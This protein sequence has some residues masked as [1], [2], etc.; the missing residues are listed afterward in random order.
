MAFVDLGEECRR[1]GLND[2]AVRV[3]RAGLAHHPD[4]LTA[5][6]TLGRALIE[7]D[8]LD[9]AFAQLTFVLDAAP[10]N[11]PATSALAEIYQRRGMMSEALVHYRRAL[12]LTQQVAERPHT[13]GQPE[14]TVAPQAPST[15]AS[16]TPPPVEDLFDFD[17]LLA[18]L[19]FSRTGEPPQA[20]VPLILPVPTPLDAGMPPS[21]DGLAVIERQLREREEQR[22]LDER[23]AR[24]ADAD[25]RR[26]ATIQELEDWL[27]AIVQ[28][29][30]SQPSA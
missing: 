2:E 14:Q 13:P 3:C 22:L 5:R 18:Q 10:G 24:Q 20:F 19:D 26:A 25:R 21:N 30:R 1:A 11:L 28:D 8:K 9:E 17:S 12:Q 15:S 23:Q 4:N 29:R 7:L 16:K 6:V 27:S